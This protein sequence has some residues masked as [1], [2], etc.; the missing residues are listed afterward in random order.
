MEKLILSEDEISRICGRLAS[1]I[2]PK[3][4]EDD[5]G[6]PIFVGQERCSAFPV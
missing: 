2:E 5:N 4:K 1:E 6:I 3:L